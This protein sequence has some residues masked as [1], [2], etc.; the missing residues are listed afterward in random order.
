[1]DRIPINLFEGRDSKVVLRCDS[2][3][4]RDTGCRVVEDNGM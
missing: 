3:Y 2:R 1:M 4:A